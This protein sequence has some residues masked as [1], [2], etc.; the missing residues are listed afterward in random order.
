MRREVEVWS[1]AGGKVRY[2][3]GKGGMGGVRR[4]G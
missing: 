2:R 3:N 1:E 4:Q